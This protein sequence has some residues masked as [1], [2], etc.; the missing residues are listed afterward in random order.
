MTIYAIA[1]AQHVDTGYMPQPT[2]ST[3][4]LSPRS[5]KTVRLTL[6]LPEDAP[7]GE[8]TIYV[9][10]STGMPDSRGFVITY[11]EKTVT[12]GE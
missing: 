6:L 5:L 2:Y 12:I 3:I 9:I 11:T 4:R 8:D 7:T 10:L 1:S